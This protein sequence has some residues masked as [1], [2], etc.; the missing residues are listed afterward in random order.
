LERRAARSRTKSNPKT[1]LLL[2]PERVDR[3]LVLAYYKAISLVHLSIATALLKVHPHKTCNQFTSVCSYLIIPPDPPPGQL[4][5]F[6]FFREKTLESS[7]VRGNKS[8]WERLLPLRVSLSAVCRGTT[9]RKNKKH[10]I[11]NKN[12]CAHAEKGTI[13]AGGNF[14]LR[15]LEKPQPTS[16]D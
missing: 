15:V 3:R 13:S 14:G 4:G 5:K 2:L 12:S 7:M 1:I 11:T 6:Q 16:A 10:N 9:D 8:S